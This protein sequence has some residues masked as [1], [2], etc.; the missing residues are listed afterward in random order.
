MPDNKCQTC[1]YW[2]PLAELPEGQG[3][4]RRF[5]PQRNGVSVHFK[6]YPQNGESKE[7]YDWPITYKTNW[8]GEF[9]EE[10]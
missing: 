7:D 1:E 6:T 9:V 4:C 2:K 10:E 8:C 5:P 3:Q